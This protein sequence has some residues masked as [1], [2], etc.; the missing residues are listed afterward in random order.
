[1]GLLPLTYRRPAYVDKNNNSLSDEPSTGQNTISNSPA[2]DSEAGSEKTEPSLRP[3]NPGSIA[4]IPTALSFDKIIEGGTCPP[5]TVRDFMNYLIYVE[6]SAENLQFFLWYRDYMKRFEQAK[7]WDL[8]LAP[9]WTPAMEEEAIQKIQKEQA[10][11]AR[12]KPNCKTGDVTVEIFKGTDFEK[13]STPV[14]SSPRGRSTS[15]LPEGTRMGSNNPFGTPPDTPRGYHQETFSSEYNGSSMATT[16]RTQASDAFATAGIK[17]PFTIQPFRK[18]IDRVIATYIMDDAPRQLNLSDKEQKAVLQALAHTTH[19][20]AFRIIITP[21]ESALRR[22]AH[23]NFI[24]WSICNGNPAR[25]FFARGLGVALILISTMVAIVLA[26][27]NAGR[28]YRALAA[29]GWVLGTSTL[30][31]AYKGMC[32][33]LHGLHHRHIRPWELFMAEEEDGEE[34][35]A[36]RSFDSF[37]SGNSYEDEPWLVRYQQRNVI[38]KIFDREVWIQEPMLRQIQDTIAVQSMLCAVVL[39]AILTAIFVAVP[40]GDL[41]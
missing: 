41:F 17:P 31:A 13:G 19:P 11:K 16:Y 2:R 30:I 9:E 22:Q 21:I 3:V 32:V 18:E 37:G 20:S 26:L 24:R 23:P 27:S 34:G 39:S 15:D 1:M 25:V 10:E 6:R 35:K 4:G 29:I 28:G 8:A 7:T 33:V 5:C 38:R 40:G 14:L 12:K 36:K